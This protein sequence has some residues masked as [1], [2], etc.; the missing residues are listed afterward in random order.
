M[1]SEV[2]VLFVAFV[3]VTFAFPGKDL[4]KAEAWTESAQP[5]NSRTFV[6]INHA[7]GEGTNVYVAHERELWKSGNHELH[8]SVNYG[9]HYGGPYG[10]SPPS[11]GGGATYR[12]R[13]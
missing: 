1:K 4:S 8:G 6:D 11:Y 2:I 7:H 9:R 13:F 10:N 5:S 12:Y 3:A